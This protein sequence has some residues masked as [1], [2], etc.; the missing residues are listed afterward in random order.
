M[1]MRRLSSGLSA[2]GPSGLCKTRSSRRQCAEASANRSSDTCRTMAFQAYNGYGVYRVAF[3]NSYELDLALVLLIMAKAVRLWCLMFTGWIFFGPQTFPQRFECRKRSK[4]FRFFGAI[5]RRMIA[6]LATNRANTPAVRVAQMLHGDSQ[7]KGIP[8][9]RK[10]IYL[11]RSDRIVGMHIRVAIGLPQPLRHEME[12]KQRLYS[13]AEGIRTSGTLELARYR[14]GSLDIDSVGFVD[15]HTLDLPFARK[16]RVLK[17]G[18]I[19]H[20]RKWTISLG[21]PTNSKSNARSLAFRACCSIFK[22]RHPISPCNNF[23]AH[24][25]SGGP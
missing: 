9:V 25:D 3:E 13:P 17:K 19:E 2:S 18:R 23:K 6:V 24:R 15:K 14:N 8:N 7:N 5:A 22:A 21:D 16:W 11:G 1:E 20:Q 10:K 4:F 12:P